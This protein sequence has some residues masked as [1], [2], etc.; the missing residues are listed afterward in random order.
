MGLVSSLRP[1]PC[2]Y[3]HLNQSSFQH[4]LRS[5]QPWAATRL[6]SQ[7]APIEGPSIEKTDDKETPKQ[8]LA[9]ENKT[10]PTESTVHAQSANSKPAPKKPKKSKPKSWD[11]PSLDNIATKKAPTESV[12]EPGVVEITTEQKNTEKLSPTQK[13]R[14]RKDET[15]TLESRLDDKARAI[16]ARR[17]EFRSRM[18]ALLQ[19]DS[20]EGRRVP[21][22]WRKNKHLPEWK[23]QIYAL[24]EKFGAEKWQ[25]RKKLSREAMDGIRTLKE[26]SPEL[27]AGDFA[28]M[29]QVPPESIRRILKSRW[30]PNESEVEKISQRWVRRGERV[31]SDIKAEARKEREDKLQEIRDRR[32][33]QEIVKAQRG[34]KPKKR[35]K[36]AQNNESFTKKKD[37]DDDD[38]DA[39]GVHSM[40][41]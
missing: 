36:N 26:H 32:R 27:N 24:R 17:P 5:H 30:S 29:F 16:L 3:L 6:L 19:E 8:D 37:D 38:D 35:K 12:I 14:I 18:E 10:N 41:F 31:K 40:I 4:S 33:E 11:L 13:P 22:G 34:I 28:K 25:P 20:E 15:D 9:V 7:L 21:K 39:F 1:Y 2:S 23:R